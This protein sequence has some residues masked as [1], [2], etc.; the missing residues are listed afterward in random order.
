MES[1]H[2]RFIRIA[3][4]RTNKILDQLKLLGNCSNRH[5]YDYTDSDVRKIFNAIDEELKAVKM[6]FY[7]NQ[8]KNRKFTLRP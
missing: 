3:E 2:D 4:S 1:K 5:N 8:E 7:V 6:K